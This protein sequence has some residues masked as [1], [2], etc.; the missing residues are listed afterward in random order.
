[1]DERLEMR[2]LGVDG[3]LHGAKS[4]EH[5]P[6]QPHPAQQGHAPRESGQGPQAPCGGQTQK[7]RC[8]ADQPRRVPGTRVKFKDIISSGAWEHVHILLLCDYRS[9]EEANH[10]R[11]FEFYLLPCGNVP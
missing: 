2:G 9:V 8:Q 10:Q 1:M 6:P 5:D 7:H 11:A 3:P 4:P